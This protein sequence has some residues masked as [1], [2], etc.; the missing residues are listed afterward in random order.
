MAIRHIED[1]RSAFPC[2]GKNL[3][4]MYKSVQISVDYSFPHLVIILVNAG[5]VLLTPPNNEFAPDKE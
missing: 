1:R 4:I 5:G 3:G 2:Q